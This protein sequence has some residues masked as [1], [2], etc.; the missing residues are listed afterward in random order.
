MVL[1]F[2]DNGRVM[3]PKAPKFKK[4]ETK[5]ERR[6][7]LTRERNLKFEEYQRESLLTAIKNTQHY[8]NLEL[9]EILRCGNEDYDKMLE[10]AKKYNRRWWAIKTIIEDRDYYLKHSQNKLTIRFDKFGEQLK[11][12]IENERKQKIKEKRI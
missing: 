1:K 10:L 4:P 3:I 2:D 12:L 11:E 6:K 9:K 5:R 8:E 7:R